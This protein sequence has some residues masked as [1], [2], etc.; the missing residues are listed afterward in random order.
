M[1]SHIQ[2]LRLSVDALELDRGDQISV[3]D[4][5]RIRRSTVVSSL[6]RAQTLEQ[7]APNGVAAGHRK[8]LSRVQAL[9]RSVAPA[10]TAG[11]RGLP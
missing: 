4:R 10:M 6:V 11:C 7:L 9:H 2:W 5:V 8:A 3:P 1:C